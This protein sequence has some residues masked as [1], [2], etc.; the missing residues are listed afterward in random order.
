MICLSDSMWFVK[1]SRRNF[2]NQLVFRKRYIDTYCVEHKT[3]CKHLR[4]ELAEGVWWWRIHLARQVYSCSTVF[5]KF[6]VSPVIVALYRDRAGARSLGR[7]MV[8]KPCL[9]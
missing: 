2:Q 1:L 4:H 7:S 8:S 6:K 9:R 3:N 5:N